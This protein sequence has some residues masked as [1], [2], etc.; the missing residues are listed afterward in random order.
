MTDRDLTMLKCWFDEY[1]RSY[2]SSDEE[3]QKN[4]MVKV[5][6]THNVC[7]NIVEIA[8][9]ESLS[10][11]QI[12]IAETIALFHDV[13]RFP[14][15]AQYKTFRDAISV[16]HGRLGAQTLT[17]EKILADLP[18]NERE[19]ITRAVI[20]HGA[21]AIPAVMNGDTVFFLKLIR[22]A[23]KV[24]IFRVFI[25]YYESPPDQRASATAFGV[26]DTPEYS[27][28]MLSCLLQKRITAYTDIKTENDF[29]IMQ[30]S[31]IYDLHFDESLRLLVKRDYLNRIIDL[32]PQTDEI[33]SALVILHEYISERLRND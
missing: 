5:E 16:S 33:K 11:N 32:L 7:R 4:I 17:Q 28:T 1:T 25:E 15:Y 8:A 30:L 27:E 9:G 29:R 19:I 18:Y 24:D 21:F 12:R 26:P 31:W 14:Q 22:D 2:Y 23:D 10:N 13:G 6:H 3:D 20:F